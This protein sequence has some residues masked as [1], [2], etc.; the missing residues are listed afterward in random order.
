MYEHI[1][2]KTLKNQSYTT[3]T[4]KNVKNP[5]QFLLGFQ[6]KTKFGENVISPSLVYQEISSEG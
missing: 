6:E 3:F 1:Y 5:I 4:G 2:L